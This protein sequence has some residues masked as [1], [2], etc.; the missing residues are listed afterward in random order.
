[1]S[2]KQ[3]LV[4]VLSKPAFK[5]EIKRFASKRQAIISFYDKLHEC[6]QKLPLISLAESKTKSNLENITA[7]FK[8]ENGQLVIIYTQLN[9]ISSKIYAVLV[10]YSTDKT[11][12]SFYPNEESMMMYSKLV[13]K[14]CLYE[15][16]KSHCD[17]IHNGP[18]HYQF[19]FTLTKYQPHIS[20][21]I[22]N[23]CF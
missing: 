3:N 23:Y 21:T 20:V 12:L 10:N 11:F 8:T 7:K 6:E 15:H 4:I 16:G 14:H 19:T 13:C 17:I 5:L 1:M 18:K 22:A 9:F 2:N